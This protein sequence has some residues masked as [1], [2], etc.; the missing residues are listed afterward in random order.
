MS[1]AENTTAVTLLATTIIT[2]LIS[3]IKNSTDVS[4]DLAMS[5]S[6]FILGA[7][8]I[9]ITSLLLIFV[10]IAIVLYCKYCVKTSYDLPNGDIEMI[11]YA[12][13][14]S[15]ALN[16]NLVNREMSEKFA[17]VSET[18]TSDLPLKRVMY[19]AVEI[20]NTSEETDEENDYCYED[21]DLDDEVD[22]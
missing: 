15:H 6:E 7:C 13:Y 8:L 2:T 5:T 9:V 18:N 10:V 16:Y 11:D 14:N 1:T 3:D 20:K 4:T 19:K 22:L 21:I 12:Q 17:S